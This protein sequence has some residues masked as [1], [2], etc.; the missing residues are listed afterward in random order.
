M[1]TQKLKAIKRII[2]DQIRGHISAY[3]NGE[4]DKGFTMD[5]IRYY[6]AA[7]F[8]SPQVFFWALAIVDAD[9]N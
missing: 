7:F 4:Q 1:N 5:C 2:N 8:G 9:L 3:R 6:R